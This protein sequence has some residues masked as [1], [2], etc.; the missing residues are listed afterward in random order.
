MNGC[1]I[2]S[3]PFR[4]QDVMWDAFSRIGYA[5]LYTEVSSWFAL[6]SSWS[7]FK[8]R[9]GGWASER[10]QEWYPYLSERLVRPD[11]V[12]TKSCNRAAIIYMSCTC[13]PVLLYLDNKMILY[14]EKWKCG[15]VNCFKKLRASLVWGALGLRAAGEPPLSCTHFD[16]RGP[17]SQWGCHWDL[18]VRLTV[19][20]SIPAEIV[21]HETCRVALPTFWWRCWGT[22]WRKQSILF[23][24]L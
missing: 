15:A 23:C 12:M 13:K 20:S 1:V 3:V 24:C 7:A 18:S 16:P 9:A 22:S 19:T 11:T 17:P 5:K 14:G 4:C 10:I 21:Q 2:T 6:C 8:L